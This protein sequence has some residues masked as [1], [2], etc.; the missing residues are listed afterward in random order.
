MQ[1]QR[2]KGMDIVELGAGV[3]LPSFVVA[4]YLEPRSLV[5]T[6]SREKLV[7]NLQQSLKDFHAATAQNLNWQHIY[8]DDTSVA[9]GK[10]ATVEEEIAKGSFDVVMGSDVIYYHPDSRPLAHVASKLL[11]PGG[12]AYIF[13]AKKRAILRDLKDQIERDGRCDS[14]E[15]EEYDLLAER[16]QVNPANALFQSGSDSS[17]KTLFEC[18]E[19]V[20]ALDKVAAVAYGIGDGAGIA[21]GE[22]CCES[23]DEDEVLFWDTGGAWV[24]AAMW[25]NKLAVNDADGNGDLQRPLR[26]PPHQKMV[27]IKATKKST[28]K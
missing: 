27:C 15:W 22:G 5:V 20:S 11:R 9:P 26:S 7:E 4:K 24:D 23:I 18:E 19:L 21:T 3:G 28:G 6:D 12:D 1:Q 10:H 8:Q 16:L 2:I 25:G 13:G 14:V 17:S